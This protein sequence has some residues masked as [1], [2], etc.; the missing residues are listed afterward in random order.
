[1]SRLREEVPLCSIRYIN[2]ASVL[3]MV[4]LRISACSRRDP[5]I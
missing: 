4:V 5:W 3:I 1:V 2:G